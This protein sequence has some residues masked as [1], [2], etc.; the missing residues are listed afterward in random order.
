MIK[1]TLYFGNPSMLSL[2]NKQLLLRFPDLEKHPE[3]KNISP[4]KGELTFPIEDLGM[5]ILDHQQITITHAL[6]S[7]LMENNVAVVTCN[8]SHHPH[9]L[10]LSLHSNT[11]Q[12][13]RYKE[14][15]EASEPLKKQ[16]WA[17]IV[18][19]KI[20]NQAKTLKRLHPKNDVEYLIKLSKNVKSGDSDNR[21][22]VAASVYWSKIFPMIENFVRNREGMPPN[23]LLNYG[24]AILRATTAR[25]IVEAGLLPTLGIHHHNRYNAYCLADD[26]MEPYRPIVDKLVYAIIIKYGIE[27]ELTKE[28][29]TELLTINYVD[30]EINGETSPLQIACQKTARS[31]QRCFEGSQRK[32]LL[33]DVI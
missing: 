3:V 26:L 1:R 31:L 4:E 22:A 7:E 19:Q 14:Q 17:Q 21:E 5:I 30:C 27:T 25:C 32:L 18:Q 10:L 29:K 20:I 13:E 23:N 24:Y 6:I 12:S 2:R 16:L 11:L 8:N 28:I 9:G 33:P 15:I